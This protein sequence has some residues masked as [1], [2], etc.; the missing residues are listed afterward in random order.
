MFIS[1]S[2]LLRFTIS[3]LDSTKLFLF[4]FARV[5]LASLQL[6][7]ME[8]FYSRSSRMFYSRVDWHRFDNQLPDRR[9]SPD[10]RSVSPAAREH[11]AAQ[12]PLIW[13]PKSRCLRNC[14]QCT[15]TSRHRSPR[16]SEWSRSHRALR[17][18]PTIPRSV[19]PSDSCCST[20]Y[21]KKKK[22]WKEIKEKQSS[23]I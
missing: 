7:Y 8:A 16:Y 12:T 22:K 3:I 6:L 2:V 21:A 15:C 17:N 23:F 9:I 10:Q 14:W 5:F 18:V 20:I 4:Q 11:W 13:S 19:P 1:I